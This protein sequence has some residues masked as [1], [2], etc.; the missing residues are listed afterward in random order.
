M[1]A[2]ARATVSSPIPVRHHCLHG[3]AIKEIHM[4]SRN[5]LL[6]II[7]GLSIAVTL[8]T[9]WAPGASAACGSPAQRMSAN[10]LAAPPLPLPQQSASDR[11]LDS[12]HRS[13]DQRPSITG[14][15]NTVYVSGGVV[16]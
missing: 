16:I 5:E 9:L 4:N 3:C 11:T 15:W 13:G 1:T 7:H 6:P 10:V 14:L 8:L 12:E 2:W